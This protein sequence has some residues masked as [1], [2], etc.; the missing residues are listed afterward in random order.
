MDASKTPAIES[1]R[2]IFFS[3][4]GIGG[5]PAASPYPLPGP[6]GEPAAFFSPDLNW[7]KKHYCSL[8]TKTYSSRLKF[9]AG[10]IK[11]SRVKTSSWSRTS[12]TTPTKRFLGKY[13]LAPE[14]KIL[15]PT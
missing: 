6:G 4:P 5:E 15:S 1:H 3:L 12:C 7:L 10:F 9:T 13:R 8:T 11:A 2:R 14:V